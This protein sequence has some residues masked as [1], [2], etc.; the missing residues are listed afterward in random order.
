MANCV[1]LLRNSEFCFSLTNYKA[2]LGILGNL[3]IEKLSFRRT[4]AYM[5]ALLPLAKKMKAS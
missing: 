1:T 5:W 2:L 3:R 4:T